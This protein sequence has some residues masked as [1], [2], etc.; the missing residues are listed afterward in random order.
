MRRAVTVGAVALS[1]A[2]AAGAAGAQP[3]PRGRSA[4]AGTRADW[5]VLAESRG[6]SAPLDRAEQHATV[7][8][9]VHLAGKDPA[10][11]EAFATAVSDPHST[12]YR[13]YLTAAQVKARFGP[14]PEHARAVRTWLTGAG[15]RITSADSHH[16]DVRGT[17]ASAE[18]AFGTGLRGYQRGGGHYLAPASDLSVPARV[19][20]DVLTV[21]DLGTA[22]RMV[23]PWSAPQPKATPKHRSGDVLP[24]PQPADVNAGPF[25]P[26]Y[27]AAPA[28]GT[29]PA[30]GSVRPWAVGGYT[31]KQLRDVYGVSGSEL[32][33]AG[34]TIAVVGAYDSPTAFADA[35]EYAGAHGDA[36]YAPGQLDRRDAPS[37][38]DTAPPGKAHPN[39]CDAAGWYGEQTLDLEA[40]HAIAPAAK[41]RYFGAATCNGSAMQDQLQRIVD[42]RLADI[43]NCSWGGPQS[44]GD[45]A[46]DAAYE[47]TFEEGAA[48]GIG[49]YFASGDDGDE[50]AATG[51]RQVGEEAGLPWVTA[52]GGTT[53]A[54]DSRGRYAFETAW[55]D[56]RADLSADG[57]RWSP[58]PGRF[59]S[60]SGGGPSRRSAQPA[61]QRGVVPSGLAGAKPHR[62]VPDVAALADPATGFLVGQAQSFPGG[63]VRYGEYRIGGT[64]LATPLVSGLQALVQQRTGRPV[65]FAN[66]ALYALRG[67]G[68]FRDVTDRRAAVVRNS[69]VN[70]LDASKGVVTSLITQA[71]DGSLRATR[72]YDAAT[73]LGSP[74]A[75]YLS[76]WH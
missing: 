57:R 17:V 4:L 41:L 51:S 59:S 76:S 74:G 13:H 30:Y 6:R 70:H 25:S 65:G 63:A 48:E 33:G 16:L 20:P 75:T 2:G 23:R 19:A 43:V 32:T 28:T 46:V 15:L 37:W 60:G 64:S 72:G 7:T 42:G 71:S 52:V 3:E 66:P 34:A 36:P 73:G 55:G 39:G 35:A 11:L 62:V 5:T 49:F 12:L 18:R 27:G 45:P 31:G 58:L 53:L 10:G 26:F 14:D 54:T 67:V 44:D 29:P 56:E 69:F 47:R 40:A 68:A 21:T 1:L 8:A 38:S 24:A 50:Q 61:Y 22:P 9:R